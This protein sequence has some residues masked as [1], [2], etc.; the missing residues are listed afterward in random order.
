M[1]L[2]HDTT[3]TLKHIVNSSKRGG[4]IWVWWWWVS[5]PLIWERLANKTIDEEHGWN[6]RTVAITVVNKHRWTYAF[7]SRSHFPRCVLAVR[8]GCCRTLLCADNAQ[9]NRYASARLDM[10]K[11]RSEADWKS[12]GQLEPLVPTLSPWQNVLAAIFLDYHHAM[13]V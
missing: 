11:D 7:A 2:R 12:S 5:S 6:L 1:P 9:H 3:D 10:R 4:E 8:V 13:S